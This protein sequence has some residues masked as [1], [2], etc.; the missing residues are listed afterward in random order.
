[1]DGGNNLHGSG[2]SQLLDSFSPVTI[3]LSETEQARNFAPDQMLKKNWKNYIF[4]YE[5]YPRISNIV[6]RLT[7]EFKNIVNLLVN[8]QF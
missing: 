3:F 8:E 5:N 2:E 4:K 1:M 6:N 7:K